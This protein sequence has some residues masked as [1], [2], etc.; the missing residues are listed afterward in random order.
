VFEGNKKSK[1]GGFSGG[2][3]GRRG[4]TKKGGKKPYRESVIIQCTAKKK[5][6]KETEFTTVCVKR[7]A[8]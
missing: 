2:K 3:G 5:N 1:T 8:S 6:G 7:K 4:E